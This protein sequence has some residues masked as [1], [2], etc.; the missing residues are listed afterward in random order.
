M[1]RSAWLVT[2]ALMASLVAAQEP[3]RGKTQPAEIEALVKQLGD[4]SFQVREKALKELDRLG[5]DALPQ[6]REAARNATDP[7]V[8]R[9]LG[10]LIPTLERNLALAPT[11]LTL[12]LRNKPLREVIKEISAA[13]GYKL[14]LQPG[15]DREKRLLNLE[16]KDTPFWEAFDQLCDLG[17][18]THQDG[19]YGNDMETIRLDYGD[20]YPGIVH[21]SGPFR[22]TVRG[23]NYYR[24]IDFANRN[25][26]VAESPI[27]RTESLTIRLGITVEPKLP[28]LQSGQPTITEAI[29]EH[30]QPLLPPG[31][32]ANTGVRYYAGYRSFTQEI[33]AS[34]QPSQNG[35][36]IKLLRGAIPVTVVASQ[37]PRVTIEK[38]LDVKG[39][40]YK[41]GNISLKIDGVT[42]NGQQIVVKLTLTDGNHNGQRDYSW[43]NQLQ[44]RLVLTDKKGNKWQ[45][46]GPSW[47]GNGFN[48]G[49]TFTGSV[50]FAN[51]NGAGEAY[52]LTYY[53]WQ[54]LSHSV[55]FEFTE[56]SLP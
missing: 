53:E 40:T 29:D 21:I 39:E 34:L 14:E 51:N 31:Q 24:N 3:S 32:V 22:V 16:F 35:R 9:R 7:E 19:Y 11:R 38:I 15:D 48:G 10:E 5:V 50:T 6:L 25:R 1:L 4:A 42:R 23:F 26:Q 44:Q 55:P 41:D 13:S 33:Q 36:M 17:G 2:L 28:L 43:I 56:L 54:T 30:G 46:Y 37:K 47:D 20:S 45:C 27:R 49:P 12:T 18:L 52:R 8:Q